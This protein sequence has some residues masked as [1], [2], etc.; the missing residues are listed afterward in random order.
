MVR[1]AIMAVDINTGKP[2]GGTKSADVF[3]LDPDNNGALLYR[4]SAAGGP[5]G[6]GR[7]GRGAIV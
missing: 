2:L 6:R 1:P 5:V 7:G 3:A 4:I